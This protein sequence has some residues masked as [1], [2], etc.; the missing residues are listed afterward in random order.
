MDLFDSF[1]VQKEL[2][3]SSID[4][5]FIP[6]KNNVLV[7]LYLNDKILNILKSGSFCELYNVFVE[8]EGILEFNEG[9]YLL[10]GSIGEGIPLKFG[11]KLEDFKEEIT[12]TSVNEDIYIQILL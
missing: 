9:T 2:L 1:P 10:I 7:Y 8:H 6:T 4:I 12:F 5:F 3:K 11:D